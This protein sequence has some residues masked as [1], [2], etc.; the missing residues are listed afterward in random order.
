MVK[1]GQCH[2]CNEEVNIF[3][4]AQCSKRNCKKIYCTLCILVHFDKVMY[5]WILKMIKIYKGL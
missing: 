5:F 2:F 3:E 1:R 4:N